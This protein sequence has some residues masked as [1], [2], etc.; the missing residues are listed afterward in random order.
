M[1]AEQADKLIRVTELADSELGCNCCE[2]PAVYEVE[3]LMKWVWLCRSHAEDLRKCLDVALA[4][5]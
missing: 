5:K 3:F 2:S 4:T 1:T